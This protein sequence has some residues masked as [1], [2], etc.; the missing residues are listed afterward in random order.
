[1]KKTIVIIGAV[2]TTMLL[3]Q[4]AKK[5]SPG[6]K[7]MTPA[8]EVAA[9]KSHYTED[10]IAKGQPIFEANCGKCHDLRQPPEFTVHQWDKI[11]PD[12][13]S[14]AKLSKDDAGVLRAWVITKAKQS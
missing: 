12:M 5:T 7:K 8:E 3:T 4:C 6:S 11:L 10:Q 14:K 1:M 2:A 13:S 9:V